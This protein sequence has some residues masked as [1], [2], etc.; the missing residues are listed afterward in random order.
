MGRIYQLDDG[1]SNM[2]AAG[3]VVENMA[4]VVKELVENAIDAE[5][6]NIDVFLADAGL[7]EI[8][9]T[10]DGIGMSKEDL[11]MAIRRHATSKIKTS[12]DLYHIHTLGFRGEA[13]PSIAS[14]S[15]F[16][17]TSS[18]GDE[19]YH[20]FLLKGELREEGKVAAKKGTNISVKYLFYNTPA[21]LKHLKASHTELSYII[22]YVQKIALSHPKISFKLT[23]N[24]KILFQSSSTEDPLKVLAQ[25]YPLDI[26]KNMIYF[27]AN[28]SYFN[29]RGYITKPMF[30]R[31]TRQHITVIANNRLIKNNR[32]V[33]AVKDGYDT[34]LPIGK[35]PIAF[36]EITLDPLLIDV[37]I[38][39]QK[40][41]V[42]FTEESTLRTLVRRTVK[43]TLLKEELIPKV[44]KQEKRPD[45]SNQ[46]SFDLKDQPKEDTEKIE[47]EQASYQAKKDELVNQILQNRHQQT[48]EVNKEKSNEEQKE[49]IK[50]TLPRL[51]YIGQFMGTYLLAQSEQ[52]LYMI[53]Q[54]AAAERIRYERYIKKMR[55][56]KI[57]T[58]ELIIPVTLDLSS[59]EVVALEG[60]LDQ[61]EQFGIKAR[62]NQ[63]QGIDITHVPTWFAKGYEGIYTEEMVSHL[64]DYK[65]LSIESVV[66]HL[67]KEL[68]CKHSIRANK[69][70][71]QNEIDVLLND[72]QNTENPYTCPHGRPVIIHF[73][74]QEIEKMFKRIM[75]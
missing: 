24:Q 37:N 74:P 75:S 46:Y 1:L 45:K 66:D 25:I 15:H 34:Y 49:E 42:K 41:E 31:S 51:E 47:E 35:N 52:G 69:F 26:I 64:L 59:Q 50:N 14:V 10:D 40:L 3:E 12:H 53:D 38:H 23:N 33:Q 62:D 18:E 48:K 8:R 4:S 54:H 9:V 13:L 20:L 67:A 65:D 6:N 2:I 56:P 63:H 55:A 57:E 5:A 32:I 11:K 39:P 27:E 60:E 70:I 36:L 21:R 71:N 29:I 68:S 7:S 44:Q 43:D 73:T 16:D 19:G 58:Y 30:T 22:D 28:D 61:L 72:L 17:I